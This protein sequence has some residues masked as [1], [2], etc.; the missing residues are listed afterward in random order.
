VIIDKGRIVADGTP[1]ELL[2]KSPTKRLDE[3]FRALT[4]PDADIKAEA[5]P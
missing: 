1:A 5:M 3:V 2:A 4:T